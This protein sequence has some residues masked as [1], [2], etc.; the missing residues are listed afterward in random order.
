MLSLQASSKVLR[1]SKSSLRQD[2][3][4]IKLS[5]SSMEGTPNCVQCVTTWEPKEN[6]VFSFCFSELASLSYHISDV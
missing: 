3:V 2:I 1:L 6:E 5:A 4:G